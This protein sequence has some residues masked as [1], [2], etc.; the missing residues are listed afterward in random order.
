MKKLAVFVTTLVFLLS[1]GFVYAE[2]EVKMPWENLSKGASTKEK[3]KGKDKDTVKKV[4]KNDKGKKT[5]KVRKKKAAE[6]A[7]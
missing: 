3:I 7:K 1:I 6:T 2:D 4:A 5:G